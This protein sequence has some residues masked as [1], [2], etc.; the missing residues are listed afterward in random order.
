[1]KNFLCCLWSTPS[2]IVLGSLIIAFHHVWINKY[3]F[4]PYGNGES[5]TVVNK[6]TGKICTHPVTLESHDTLFDEGAVFLTCD[7]FPLESGKVELP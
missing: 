1:M 3:E 4:I 2:A 5:F 6:W 7:E